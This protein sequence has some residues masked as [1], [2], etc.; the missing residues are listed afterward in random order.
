M[1]YPSQFGFIEGGSCTRYRV[2][3]IYCFS[4]GGLAQPVELPVVNIIEASLP[5][6]PTPVVFILSRPRFPE[7]IRT[8]RLQQNAP[9][10]QISLRL[11]RARRCGVEISASGLLQGHFPSTLTP[12]LQI[13]SCQVRAVPRAKDIAYMTRAKAQHLKKSVPTSRCNMETVPP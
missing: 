10:V 3:L 4:S 1:E 13:F 11:I 12:A 8:S 5:T 2:R 9:L 7:F 6:K